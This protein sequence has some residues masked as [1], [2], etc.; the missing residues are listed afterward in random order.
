MGR[1]P[2]RRLFAAA[3]IVIGALLLWMSP[4]APWGAATMVAG[5]ALEALGI[6]LDHA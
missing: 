4:E 3:L 2:L 1:K 6:R 5:L